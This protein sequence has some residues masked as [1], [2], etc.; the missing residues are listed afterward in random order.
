MREQR[1][2][3]KQ[4]CEDLREDVGERHRLVFCDQNGYATCQDCPLQLKYARMYTLDKKR[5]MDARPSPWLR[6]RYGTACTRHQELE[7]IT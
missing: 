7:A 3:A 6:E 4:S 1:R 5:S 2:A